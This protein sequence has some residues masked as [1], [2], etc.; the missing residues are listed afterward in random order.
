[1]DG[2]TSRHQMSSDICISQ[3]V[4]EDQEQELHAKNGLSECFA[5]VFINQLSF[6]LFSYGF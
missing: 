2:C 6:S 1:M 5:L 4:E 3:A